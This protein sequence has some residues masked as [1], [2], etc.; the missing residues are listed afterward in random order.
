MVSNKSRQIGLV[1]RLEIQRRNRRPI[2]EIK[3]KTHDKLEVSLGALTAMKN[4]K[5]F[6]VEITPEPEEPDLITA[7]IIQKNRRRLKEFFLVAS[8]RTNK[9]S[10]FEVG[11][12]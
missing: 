10:S 5:C 1:V 4:P 8:N 7:R 9:N 6:S 2:L 12:V 3:A 11:Q